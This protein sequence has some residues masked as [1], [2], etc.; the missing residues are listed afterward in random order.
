MNFYFPFFLTTCS[1]VISF[2]CVR[3]NYLM[4]FSNSFI[5]K[6][7]KLCYSVC[8]LLSGI[9]VVPLVLISACCIKILR[10]PP[11]RYKCSFAGINASPSPVR[12]STMDPLALKTWSH[13]GDSSKPGMKLD[14]HSN[15]VEYQKNIFVTSSQ[16]FSLS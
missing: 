8:T 12:V 16:I 11:V 6:C 13:T 1:D 5:F 4:Y 7:L 10:R 2:A 14:I 3:L 9:C 15:I